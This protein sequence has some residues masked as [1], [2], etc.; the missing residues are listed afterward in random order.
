MSRIDGI[1][2]KIER[3]KKHIHDLETAMQAFR[4]SKPYGSIIEDD[5]QSG[6]KV[7]RLKI[8]ADTP[9]EFAMIVGDAVHN[10][11][12]S[13]DYLAWQLVEANRCVPDNKTAFPIHDTAS[14]YIA[15]APRQVQ[16]VSP[17]AKNLIE[18]VQPYKTGYG[19]IGI[20]HQLDIRD[21]H[22]LMVVTA[23]GN[24]GIAMGATVAAMARGGIQMQ[25]GNGGTIGAKP[26]GTL[27]M[28][29]DGAVLGRFLA[30][31]A[32]EDNL[33]FEA[34]FDI[35]FGE[36]QIVEGK[37]V[38]PLLTQL[39]QFLDSIVNQFVPFL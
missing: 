1:R 19:D 2:A 24:K 27:T 3:A 32:T 10:L 33:N 21:K 18:A 5:P 14:K 16:G 38:I 4:D 12:A 20:L 26:D 29:Q 31:T 23:F 34:F 11:R 25:L 30:P 17:A 8:F 9:R 36:P 7:H 13:L 39:S 35:A 15:H 28:L 6:D 37:P 22:H